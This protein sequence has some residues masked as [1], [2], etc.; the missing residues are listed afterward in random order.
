MSN[1]VSQ[2]EITITAERP[3][4]PDSLLLLASLRA[5]LREKYPD[6]LRGFSPTP[7]EF[8]IPGAVFVVARQS[9]KAVGCGAI[10]PL[11][12]GV[13]EVKRMFVAR[14]A[15]GCG[16][17]K[18]VLE[19]LETLARKSGYRVIRL[20]TGLKQPEAI[21]LYEAAGFKPYPC[22]GPYATNPLSVCFEKKLK[23]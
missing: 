2:N 19:K 4:K 18:A 22:Y 15:R 5:E 12:P 11:A 7:D 13:A 16:V 6:E 1:S 20:E 9:G 14:E 17:G 8:M 3:D 21:A 23:E 10:R